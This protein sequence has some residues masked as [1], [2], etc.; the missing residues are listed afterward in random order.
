MIMHPKLVAPSLAL[1]LALPVSRP[2]AAQP[3]APIQGIS[4]PDLF[5]KS[6]EAAAEAVTQYGRWDKPAEVARVH[7]IGYELA[8][9]T[10]FTKFPL[11]F[12]VIDMAEPN[13]MALPG[14]QIFVTRGMLELGVDDDMLANVIGHEIGHVTH[15]HAIK[16]QRRAT[17]MNVLGNLMTVGVLVGAERASRNSNSPQA[18]YDPRY[19]YD[20]GSRGD[21]V[22]GAAAASLVI[23]ELLLRS[24]SRDSE[25][26]A[27][28]EGQQLS[29]AA[30]YNPDGA[31]KLWELMSKRAPQARQYGYWQTH[32]FA[33]DRIKAAQIRKS[34]WTIEKRQSADAY[35]QRTQG[36]LASFL[37]RHKP[38]KENEV[39]FLK[40]GVLA[41]WPQSKNADAIRLDRLHHQR[42]AALAKPLLSRD[43]GVVIKAYAKEADEVKSLDPK[44]EILATF[45]SESAE[46]DAK[47]K[48]LYPKAAEVVAGGIYETP[49]L[50]AFLSNFPDA[51]EVPKVALS[52]GDAY[53]RL[54]NQTDAV[55]NYMAAL[56]AAPESPEGKR[57]RLGLKNLAPT[58]KTLAA[59]EQLADQKDDPELQKLSTARLAAVVKSYDT[60][61][62]GAEYLRRFPESP[63]VAAVTERLNVL[64]ENLYGE[65]VL[66]QGFGDPV[67]AIT[68]INKIMTNAPLSPAAVKLR[69][70][71]ILPDADPEW[72]DRTVERPPAPGR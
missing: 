62:N 23:S 43:Y 60:L 32:P 68:R 45:A 12:D 66:Y 5:G 52:L 2:V 63:H 69:E 27:D 51:P 3:Q 53:S 33:E 47:R 71:A 7:R 57:A 70:R 50:V 65:V 29:A 37:E 8:Q 48:E 59:L 19:G 35:R 11:T 42:D 16:M 58:L 31:Q 67:K 22:Q 18:P 56:E 15:E 54:G 9:K 34:G 49:F 4:N 41:T 21:L 38:K 61:E 36:T 40:D 55:K 20:N 6:L 14:G 28:V 17:L 44:A 10:G 46:L 1:L 26:E 24:Y 64:A 30:G 72:G 25:D 39:E 13:A